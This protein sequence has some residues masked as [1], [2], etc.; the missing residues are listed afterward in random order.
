MH[1]ARQPCVLPVWPGLRVQSE[2]MSHV[3]AVLSCCPRPVCSPLHPPQ[4]QKAGV[5]RGPLITLLPLPGGPRGQKDPLRNIIYSG[6]T[7]KWPERSQPDSV[8]VCVCVRILRLRLFCGSAAARRSRLITDLGHVLTGV[9]FHSH[10][11]TPEGGA[12]E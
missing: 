2:L 7:E 6:F 9:H 4:S 11:H 10:K 1:G 5:Q 12:A 3:T 8:R